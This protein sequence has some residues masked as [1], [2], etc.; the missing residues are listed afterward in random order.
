MLYAEVSFN[1]GQILHYGRP[2]VGEGSFPEE[3]PGG[4]EGDRIISVCFSPDG[5]YVGVCKGHCVCVYNTEVG[6][7]MAR[8]GV[9]VT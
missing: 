2:C 1:Q 3:L 4:S 7:V 9:W 8:V 6:H 5:V